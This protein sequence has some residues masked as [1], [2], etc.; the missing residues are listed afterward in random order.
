MHTL[1]GGDEHQKK[2]LE[3]G[4]FVSDFRENY[5]CTFNVFDQKKN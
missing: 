5:H 1:F 2:H 3:Y 4:I